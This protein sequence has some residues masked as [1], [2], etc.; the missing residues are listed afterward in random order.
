MSM[1]FHRKDPEFLLGR[2][3]NSP[4]DTKMG[5]APPYIFGF[6][7]NLSKYYPFSFY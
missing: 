5:A 1:Y 4:F 3:Y 7:D 2:D 6:R